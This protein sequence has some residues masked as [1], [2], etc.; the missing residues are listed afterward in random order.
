MRKNKYLIVY[1]EDSPVAREM[2]KDGLAGSEYIIETATDVVD[3]ENRV[4]LN[5]EFLSEVD[6]FILD[7]D[8][9]EMTGTQI[10]TVL[11]QA[12][13]ELKGKPFVIFSGRPRDEVVEAIEDACNYSRSFEKNFKGY[14]EKKGG[15]VS[16]LL[17][18]IRS[19]V[20]EL[21][22]EKIRGP[23]SERRG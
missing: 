17:D 5:E 3:L 14:V 20:A 2:V 1:V 22:K 12:H 23:F 9:P 10:A 4:L 7:F 13:R 16:D 15:S 21:G 6:L 11:E 19:V 18:K 8:M